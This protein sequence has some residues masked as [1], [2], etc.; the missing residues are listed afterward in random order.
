[1]SLNSSQI[2]LVGESVSYKLSLI[3]HTVCTSPWTSPH[4]FLHLFSPSMVQ[5]PRFL[6]LSL[7]WHF[8]LLSDVY[9]TNPLL[10]Q[11]LKYKEVEAFAATWWCLHI[12]IH[13][14]GSNNNFL[15]CDESPHWRKK[16]V[17]HWICTLSKQI[18][19]APSVESWCEIIVAGYRILVH[20]CSSSRSWF[21][22]LIGL[23]NTYLFKWAADDIYTTLKPSVGK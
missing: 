1:M 13:S 15:P 7:C 3:K 22:T 16:F 14:P 10:K 18:A 2:Q 4:Q 17:R 11:R 9:N 12:P 5:V 23:N 21:S 8:S 6:F 19:F 20:G